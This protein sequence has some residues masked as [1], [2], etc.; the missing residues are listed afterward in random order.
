MLAIYGA[1]IG[2]IV[3][4]NLGGS[5]MINKLEKVKA[6]VND[7]FDN[8]TDQ[9]EKRVAYTHSY[10]VA[11]CCNI[12]AVKRGLDTTLAVAIGLL[13][14]VYS[15]KTRVRKLHAPNG[16]EMVRVAFK[17]D[18]NGLFTNE[19]QVLIQSAIYHHSDKKHIHDKYDELL[20]DADTLQWLSFQSSYEFPR[21]QRMLRIMKELSLPIETITVLQQEE[22]SPKIFK[23]YCVGEIA[24]TLAE[25][26]IVGEKQNEDYMRII[27][28]FPEKSSFDELKNA[29]CAAFVYHCC[30]EA[31]LALPIRFPHNVKNIA[32]CRF[33]CVVAWYEWGASNGYCYFEKDGYTP[34]HGDIVI[35]NNI[36]PKEDKPDNSTW[37]DHIGVVL[38]CDKNELTVAEGNIGN[39]NVTGIVKRKRDE[40]IGCYIHIPE[41][42]TYSGW[43]TDFKTGETKIINLQE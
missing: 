18:L 43:E 41:N 9:D 15:Y 35:Y 23:Q 7:I 32:G 36:I 40:T 31:K 14:D 21:A 22:S 24:K 16:A 20:K 39:K 38:Y 4:K 25:K 42:Y 10:C 26:N 2:F 27:R 28:Y 3:I 6:Y 17:Y 19:D 30:I 5:K 29:W 37:C 8:I 11:E 33:A 34:E 13:H 12:L 1:D